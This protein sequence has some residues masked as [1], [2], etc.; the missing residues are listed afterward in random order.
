MDRIILHCD[1]NCFYAS[2]EMLSHEDL[3]KIPVAVCGD[4]ASRH[5]II[6]AKNEPAKKLGVQTAETIWQA[7]KKCPDLVLLPPH[8]DLYRQYSRMVN[9]IYEQYT[10]LVEPFGID[11]SWLDVTGSIHLFGGDPKALADKL[12]ERVKREMGLTLSVGVSFNKVFAKLG[13]DYKKPDATTVISRENWKQLVWPLPVGDLLFVGGAAQK[14]LHQYGIDT[15]GALA[16]CRQDMLSS[17]M[18][19]M[20]LQLHEYANGLD[21]EPVRS[22]ENREPVKSIG[23]GTTFPENLTTAE[24][25][26]NS[27]AVLADSVASRLRHAGLYACG[28]HVTVRDP[29]FHDRSR[30]KQL[31]SPTCLIRDLAAA[32]TELVFAL[33]KPPFPVRMLT[34]T[35][36]HLLPAEDAY[37]QMN[38]FTAALA[39]NREKQEKLESA[40]ERIRGKYGTGAICFGTTQLE[41]EEDP[42]A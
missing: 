38:L 27:I 14:L 26:H 8:H 35:A 41:N 4:P 30:Q 29:E 7:K 33:W 19:K 1:L 40:M 37:E 22:R 28:I 32:A 25:V 36:I 11:E 6:L 12:R 31:S 18:G 15:I 34:V 24:Q 10:D 23:N 17:L 21:R 5:G 16:A 2:V 3:R 42:L 13:S 9:A 20:G 39:P